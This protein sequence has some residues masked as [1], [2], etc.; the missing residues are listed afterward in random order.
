MLVIDVSGLFENCNYRVNL[1][2]GI[3]QYI[4]SPGYPRK[5]QIGSS[6][7]YTIY[8]P[9]GF[10]VKTVCTLNMEGPSVSDLP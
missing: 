9:N 8:A 10:N 2:T 3:S 5:F 6:C 7:Q 4:Y 1:N